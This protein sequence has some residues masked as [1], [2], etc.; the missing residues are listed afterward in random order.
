[1]RAAALCCIMA[2][3]GSFVPARHARIGILDRIFTRVGAF[4]DLASG[5][6]T[7]FVEMLELANI[8][9]NVTPRS[10]VILDEIGRGTSTADGSSIARAVLEFLHGKSGTGPKTLFA[11]HFHELIAME[12]RLKRVANY[13]FA[14]KETNNEVVFLRKLIPGATDKSYGIHVARLAGIPRKVTER[15]EALLDE[16][17]QRPDGNGSKP[18]RYTQILLVDEKAETRMPATHPVA[19]AIRQLNPDEIT[20]L[21]ALAKIAELKRMLDDDGGRP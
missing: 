5:Q 9:N 13:H 3:A 19:E 2:Q 15:A 16:E 11:T 1:M 4:D 21:Q 6:S 7:F 12:E 20:P 18:R 17:A 10:L 8:L 14:V